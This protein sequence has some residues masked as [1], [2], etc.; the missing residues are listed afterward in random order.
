MSQPLTVPKLAF[1]L[2]SP[3]LTWQGSM[4]GGSDMPFLQRRYPLGSWS[5]RK[6]IA[7]QHEWWTRAVWE[8]LRTDSSVP[9]S[10][11]NEA[12]T[13]GL[14]ADE[15]ADNGGFPPQLYAIPVH[16][17]RALPLRSTVLA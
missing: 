13:W 11:R 17:A 9:L 2:P 6:A 8:F 12:A 10:I 15:W 5:E 4:Q 14:P 7:A 16:A 1:N 3:V